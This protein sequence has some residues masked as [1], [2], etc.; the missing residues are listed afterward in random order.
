MYKNFKGAFTEN[1]V[2]TEL[3]KQGIHPYFWRSGNVAELDFLFE[4]EDKIIPVEAKAEL[5]T[6]A[7]S[8]SQYCKKYHPDIGFMFSMKNVGSHEVEETK[9]YS[10][11]LYL[12]WTIKAYLQN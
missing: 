9:T 8:Y 11:P 7:K 1:F 10:V 5:H 4:Y 3:M 6:R 2:L 12:L